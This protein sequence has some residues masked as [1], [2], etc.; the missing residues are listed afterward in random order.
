MDCNLYTERG[1]SLKNSVGPVNFKNIIIKQFNLEID[2][3]KKPSVLY[4]AQG[5]KCNPNNG[6]L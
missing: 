6:C 4:D 1:N 3:N 5:L 2:I